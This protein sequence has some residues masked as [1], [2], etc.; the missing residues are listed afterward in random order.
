MSL[1]EIDGVGNTTAKALLKQFKTISAVKAA[2]VSALC[3][4]EGVGQKTAEK[5][6]A[7]YHKEDENK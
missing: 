5:I 1:T 2:S 3:A 6:Y 4:A 7:Y